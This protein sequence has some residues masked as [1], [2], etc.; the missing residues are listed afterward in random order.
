MIKAIIFD[1]GGVLKVNTDIPVFNDIGA[2]FGIDPDNVLD[3]IREIIH[4]LESGKITEIESWKMFSEKLGKPIPE[5]CEDLWSKAYI[6][7]YSQRKEMLE[8]ARELKKKG[9]I[10]AMLSNTIDSHA[11][12]NKKM[13]MYEPFNPCIL[14]NEVKS[15]KPEKEIYEITIKEIGLN[16]EECVFIDDKEEYIK[17]ANDLGM[18]GIVFKDYNQLIQDLKNIGVEI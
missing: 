6:K 4:E 11:A 14:S 8:F 5:G 12:F 3:E 9:F 7:N 10:V 18:Q 1:C 16:P 2:A 13:G 15:R 17:V